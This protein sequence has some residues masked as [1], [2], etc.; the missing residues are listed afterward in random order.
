MFR[1]T[2]SIVS[3][4]SGFVAKRRQTMHHV[5]ASPSFHPAVNIRILHITIMEEKSIIDNHSK[6]C[7]FVGLTFCGFQEAIRINRMNKKWTD[8]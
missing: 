8:S 6:S 7:I 5:S 4:I 1:A 3:T 2:P